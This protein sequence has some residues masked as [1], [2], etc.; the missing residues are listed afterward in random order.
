MEKKKCVLFVRVSTEYQDYTEQTSNLSRYAALH[1]Y[2]L[3]NQVIIANKE[4]GTKLSFEDREGFTQL[5]KV[6]DE[7]EVTAVFVAEVSRIGRRDDVIARFKRVL[8]ERKIN[9]YVQL[10]EFRLFNEDGSLNSNGIIMFNI[11]ATLA[12]REMIEKKSR[13][14][15]GKARAVREGRLQSGK[16]MFGY[17]YD[18]EKTRLIE[19]EEAA[20]CVR[21]IYNMYAR[22]K[23]MIE[24]YDF[25][26]QDGRFPE[27]FPLKTDREIKKGM[28]AQILANASYCGRLRKR[29]ATRY[30]AI[31]TE[32][33]FDEVAEARKRRKNDCKI[34]TKNI[35]YAKQL[36]FYRSK[37]GKDYAMVPLRGTVVYKCKKFKCALSINLIDTIVLGEA[38]YE[39]FAFQDSVTEQVK[40]MK[41]RYAMK[42]RELDQ[43]IKEI[44]EQQKRLDDIYVR[45]RLTMKEY[46][47]RMYELDEEKETC[48]ASKLEYAQQLSDA[49]SNSKKPFLAIARNIMEMDDVTRKELVKAMIEKVVVSDSADGKSKRI[50]VYTK[51]GD[52]NTYRYYVRSREIEFPTVLSSTYKSMFGFGTD[53][54]NPL[55][56]EYKQTYGSLRMKTSDFSI[57]RFSRKKKDK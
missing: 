53:L 25:L 23:S 40:N 14:N 47:S 17:K 48:E 16:P 22:G 20:S 4:S 18:E 42:C 45:G 38:R 15:R 37:E 3:E 56:K 41:A 51:S 44:K 8:I 24:I 19:D 50:D 39:W 5:F 29:C 34:N 30:P 13:F 54:E 31:I 9:L 26:V 46:D 57:I 43:K 1:G 12:E 35:Y 28:I 6:L 27:K 21:D 55:L 2:P 49:E 52:L 11:V 32:K 33:M 36:I 10:D 7:G